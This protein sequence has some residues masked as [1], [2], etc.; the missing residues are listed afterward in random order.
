MLLG[1]WVIGSDNLK[2]D[3]M[4]ILLVYGGYAIKSTL[5]D[6]NLS[7]Y[8]KIQV[9]ESIGAKFRRDVVLIDVLNE[10][11]YELN[12]RTTALSG[13]ILIPQDQ[14]KFKFR[15]Q[16]LKSEQAKILQEQQDITIKYGK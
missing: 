9:L 12:W 7:E 3:Y 6:P 2:K 4:D 15:I 1:Y 14:A 16:D 11:S 10:I 13:N 5:N 8:D